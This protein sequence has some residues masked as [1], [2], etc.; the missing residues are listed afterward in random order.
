MKDAKKRRLEID[1][2]SGEKI[3]KLVNELY[4]MPVKLARLTAGYRKPAKVGE[5]KCEIAWK[6]VSVAVT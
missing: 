1:S 3:E 5:S 4:A 6:T 2:I